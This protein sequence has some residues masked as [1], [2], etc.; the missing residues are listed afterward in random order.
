MSDRTTGPTKPS[1]YAQSM[2]PAE[3]YTAYEQA[4]QTNGLLW[5]A[6][7]PPP[8]PIGGWPS[9]QDVLDAVA[10]MAQWLGH[11]IVIRLQ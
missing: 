3:F 10:R 2:T 1:V 6:I 7:P 5:P 11:P 9:F 8:N 4:R